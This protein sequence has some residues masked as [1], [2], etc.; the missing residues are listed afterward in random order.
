MSRRRYLCRF[1]GYL[2]AVMSLVLYFS[3][4]VG[5]VSDVSSDVNL[6]HAPTAIF[7]YFIFRP[8][9]GSAT[10][11]PLSPPSR[12][13]AHPTAY[14]ALISYY[15]EELI[16]TRKPMH[17]YSACWF[18]V[19]LRLAREKKE[20]RQ[21]YPRFSVLCVSVGCKQNSF[22]QRACGLAAF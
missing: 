20:G 21:A 9:L 8:S 6:M 7:N 11:R 12:A 15:V 16:G 1:R 17:R 19:K 22:R 3:V 13:Q 5:V 4:W 10:V 18:E 14:L 2:R